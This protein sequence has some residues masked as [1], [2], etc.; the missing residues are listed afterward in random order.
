MIDPCV[1]NDRPVCEG[2]VQLQTKHSKEPIKGAKVAANLSPSTMLFKIS[3][4]LQIVSLTTLVS[5]VALPQSNN[6]Y[7]SCRAPVIQEF[8]DKPLCTLVWVAAIC[9][10][11]FRPGSCCT[12]PAT[13]PAPCQRQ[14]KAAVTQHCI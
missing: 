8:I 2:P 3:S 7:E 11:S 10:E 5:A 1:I 13:N 9:G 12:N 14:L 4:L 6:C